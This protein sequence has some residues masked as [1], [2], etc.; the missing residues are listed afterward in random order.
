M[1]GF[2]LLLA[3]FAVVSSQVICLTSY[4]SSI[5]TAFPGVDSSVFGTMPFIANVVGRIFFALVVDGLV[6]RCGRRGVAFGNVLVN[7]CYVITFLILLL[8]ALAVEAPPGVLYFAIVLG[9]LTYGGSP[10]FASAFV[11][12]SYRPQFIGIVIGL[13]F[14]VGAVSAGVVNGFFG[15]EN[16]MAAAGIERLASDFRRPWIAGLVSSLLVLPMSIK[17]A[18]DASRANDGGGSWASASLISLQPREKERVVSRIVVK[19]HE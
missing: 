14:T 13:M 16:Q 3:L 19:Q 17:V 5:P 7:T 12:L 11:K 8:A 9:Y 4:L 2:C 10:C 6:R 1:G 18:F 15:P